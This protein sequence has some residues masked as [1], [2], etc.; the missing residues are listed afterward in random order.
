MKNTNKKSIELTK[1][2][3]FILV[4]AVYM[5]NWMANAHRDGSPEDPH[6]KEY[7]EIADYV[8]SLATEFGFPKN[9]EHELEYDQKETTEIGRLHE[10]YDENIFWEELPERLG[11]RDFYRKYSKEDWAKMTHEEIFLNT[12]ECVI[13]WEEE[14]EE[15]G[16][17]RLAVLKQAKDF[18]IDV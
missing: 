16:I 7:E 12:Q 4:K 11:E 17:E 9:L 14:L 5:G 10:E 8:F 3:Y 1:E 13:A 2:Q 6:F 18:G 15:H